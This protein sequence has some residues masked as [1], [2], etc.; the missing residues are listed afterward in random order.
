[1][2]SGLE[3][4]LNKKVGNVHIVRRDK[5]RRQKCDSN[6]RRKGAQIQEFSFY[7][8]LTVH[9]NI[10][11]VFF[12]FT[13]LMRKFFILIYLLYSCTCFKHYCAHLQE[14]N[15]ISTASVIV[16]VQCTGYERALVTCVLNSHLKRVTIPGAVLIQ[17]PS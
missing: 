14:D 2:A 3:L 13:N 17:L 9:P 4:I 12:F 7:I 1:M 5:T 6:G 11:V 8:L 16:T 15:C 10:V